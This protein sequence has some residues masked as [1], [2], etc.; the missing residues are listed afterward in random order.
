MCRLL[1]MDYLIKNWPLLLITISGIITAIATYYDDTE[2][3][4]R[5][6]WPVVLIAVAGIVAVIGTFVSS[7]GDAAQKDNIENLGKENKELNTEIKQLEELDTKI[8]KHNEQLGEENK[9]LTGQSRALIADVK[10]LTAKSQQLIRTINER[11]A[12]EAAENLVSGELK[13]DFKPTFHNDEITVILGN[14]TSTNSMKRLSNG[15]SRLFSFGS[16]DPITFNFAH[17]KINISST[18]FDQEGNLIAEIDANSWRPNKNMIC[19][20]NYDNRGLE[21]IDNKRRIVFNID[22]KNDSLVIQGVFNDSE[23]KQVWI[24][25]NNG[26][27]GLDISR[28][29]EIDNLRTSIRP[30]FV[31]TGKN[32]LH[33]RLKGQPIG[34]LP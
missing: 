11:T 12:Y 13:I 30:L 31:Y 21:V 1:S 14:D 8:S 34:A 28:Q 27:N 3:S 26:M 33:K 23:H 7:N 16:Q 9:V 19:R 32:W 24:Y 15:T 17:N 10:K 18:I 25:G 20:F 5:I 4:K 22:I 6:K 29:R 2:G